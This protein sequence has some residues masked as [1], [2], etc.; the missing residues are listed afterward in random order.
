MDSSLQDLQQIFEYELKRKLSE[1]AKSS[2]GELRVLLNGFRFFDINYTGIITKTQW[3]QGILRAGL[4]GFSES[5]LDSLFIIYDQNN[6]G[7]IDYKNFCSFLY[8]REPL[9]PLTNDSQSLKIEQNNSNEIN[10]GNNTQEVNNNINNQNNFSNYSNNFG[11]SYNKKNNIRESPF[12]NDNQ[13]NIINNQRRQV[14]SP[15]NYFNNNQNDNFGYNL[16]TPIDNAEYQENNNFRK[17]QRKIN[18]YTNTFNNIFQQETMQSN[19][20]KQNNYNLSENAINSIIMT[21]KNNIN[22]NNGIK[23]FSFIKYLRMRESNGSQISINDLYN[24]FQEMRIKIPFDELKIFFNYANKNDSDII[25]TEQLINIIKGNLNEQRKLY[26]VDL[27]SKIDTEHT[28]KIS[29][30]L[31]KNTFNAKRHPEVINGTKSLEEVLEQFCYSLDLYCEL[32][33]IQKNGELTF[34]NFVDYYSCVSASIPDEVYFEDMINGVWSNIKN[35]NNNQDKIINNNDIK[36]NNNCQINDNKQYNENNSDINIRTNERKNDAESN[37]I[38]QRNNTNNYLKNNNMNMNQINYNDER[39]V[40]NSMSSPFI[41]GNNAKNNKMN[42]NNNFGNQNTNIITN[43]VQSPFPYN[44]NYG[45]SYNKYQITAPK[46][47]DNYVNKNKRRYNPILDE[48]YPE[49][50]NNKNDLNK[51]DN[52]PNNITKNNYQTVKN[53]NINIIN[54]ET[55]SNN[56]I[57]NTNNNLNSLNNLRNILISRGPKSIFAFQRMLTIYDRNNS[58]V[59]SLDDFINIFQIYNL[60]IPDS[61]IKNIFNIY[62]QNQSGVINY[63]NLINDLIGQI[64][65]KRVSLLQKVFNNF[66]KNEQGE[67]SIKEIKQKFNPGGHPDVLS[68]KKTSNEVFG[69]FLDM[70]EIYREYIY[71]IRG[72]YITSI[73]FE[74]F[75]QFYAEISLSIKDDYIFENMMMNCWNLGNSNVFSRNN[76]SVGNNYDYGG[77]IRTRTGQQ[78]INMNNKGY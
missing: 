16:R 58:G 1:R 63:P 50:E 73:N 40:K 20:I 60:N 23:L 74:D 19:I 8:G 27:F 64:S 11:K 47:L 38:N 10:Y 68:R 22:I 49:I 21:I 62:N 4:T 42:Y 26:I 9:N 33:G 57:N 75:K 51:D 5:D 55:N 35:I 7:Q 61:E 76:D 24:I 15:N 28:N 30:Q 12:N 17:S 78:I 54:K 6:T 70:L 59:I 67:V 72:G 25:S 41:Y 34:E 44:S 43:N 39:K 18:S 69:E 65:E 31:L 53:T 48:Y 66:N 29:I 14:N 32:N 36:I 2:S 46:G 77:N 45:K 56:V 37:G 71:S 13:Y 3:I 52:N